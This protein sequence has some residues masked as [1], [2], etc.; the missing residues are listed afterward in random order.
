MNELD[1]IRET[2]SEFDK[3]PRQAL[4]NALIEAHVEI[5]RIEKIRD[6]YM[7]S[8][9]IKS[10]RADLHAR[11]C[12]VAVAIC[13]DDEQGLSNDK[14]NQIADV[15]WPPPPVPIT[16]LPTNV[17]M[18]IATG[19]IHR[20]QIDSD[21]RVISSFCKCGAFVA[22]IEWAYMGEPDFLG[23]PTWGEKEGR[24]LATNAYALLDSLLKAQYTTTLGDA[25]SEQFS[26]WKNRAA[27]FEAKFKS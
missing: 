15:I 2:L 8:D 10:K 20:V 27:N 12:E 4:L 23:L 14:L 3:L 11:R 26:E 22:D 1:H 6:Q 21:R 24:I 9:L 16:D 5:T 25:W 17:D 18:P 13:R 19:H 7:H